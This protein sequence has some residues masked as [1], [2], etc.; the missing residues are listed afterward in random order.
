[1]DQFY[2]KGLQVVL[3]RQVTQATEDL[4]GRKE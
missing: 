3:E 2:L 4:Q 1:M